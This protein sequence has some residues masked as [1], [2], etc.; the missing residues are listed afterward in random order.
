MNEPEMGLLEGFGEDFADFEVC[1]LL[2]SSLFLFG[3]LEEFRWRNFSVIE[4]RREF[5]VI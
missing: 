1:D 5:H 2:E 3:G 4:I